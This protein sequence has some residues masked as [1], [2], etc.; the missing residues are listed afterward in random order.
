MEIHEVGE[1]VQ[2]LGKESRGAGWCSSQNFQEGAIGVRQKQILCI[3]PG[4]GLGAPVTHSPQFTDE[5]TES[6]SWDI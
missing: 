6:Q 1:W 3:R 4:G 5:K 2:I